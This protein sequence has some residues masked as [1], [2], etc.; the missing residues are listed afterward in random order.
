[1]GF[2]S[3][4]LEHAT[5]G[6]RRNSEPN[7]RLATPTDTIPVEDVTTITTTTLMSR[8][9]Q[10]AIITIAA[11]AITIMKMRSATMQN[12]VTSMNVDTTIIAAGADV[13]TT[14]NNQRKRRSCKFRI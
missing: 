4:I 11:V 7:P 2:S 6:S 10:N 1:M 3:V 5:G 12:V 9:S 13:V 14:T 8:V